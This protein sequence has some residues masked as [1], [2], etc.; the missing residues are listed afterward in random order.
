[1]LNQ[2]GNG[3]LVAEKLNIGTQPRPKARKRLCFFQ[4]IEVIQDNVVFIS[5]DFHSI[6]FSFSFLF[7]GALPLDCLY[8]TTDV[9]IVNRFFEKSLKN[10]HNKKACRSLKLM[11]IFY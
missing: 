10:F 6:H 1:M 2:G 8:Y 11:I 9:G 7:I 3:T 4:C 5:G